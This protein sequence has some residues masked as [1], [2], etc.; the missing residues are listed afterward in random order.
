MKLAFEERFFESVSTCHLLCQKMKCGGAMNRL[1][2]KIGGVQHEIFFFTHPVHDKPGHFKGHMTWGSNGISFQVTLTKSGA[3]FTPVASGASH[4]GSLGSP[5]DRAK[6]VMECFIELAR[7]LKI[8]DSKK[9]KK[10]RGGGKRNYVPP[11]LNALERGKK[12]KTSQTNIEK[13]RALGVFDDKF[14]AALV[15]AEVEGIAC[16]G[17]GKPKAKKGPSKS[18]KGSSKSVQ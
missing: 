17:V 14:A 18:K 8:K 3:T 2:L 11:E 1:E 10:A 5:D 13:Y 15:T 6:A 16:K 12:L 4:Y 7:R 9:A